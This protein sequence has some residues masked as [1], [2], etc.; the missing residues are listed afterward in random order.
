MKPFAAWLLGVVL[1]PFV[2]LAQ[3]PAGNLNTITGVQVKGGTVTITGTQKANFTTFTMTDPPRLV[4]DISEATFSGVPEEISVSS[5]TVTG[6]R[7]ASYGSESSSIARVLIGY[8]REVE[9]DI[10]S[11]GNNL[12]VRVAGGGEHAVAQAPTPEQAPAGSSAADAAAAARADRAAQEKA[13]ADAA[14]AARADREAQERA[15]AD[16]AAAAKR[17]QEAEAKRQAEARAAAQRQ[18]EEQARATA[19]AEAERKRQQEAE[20]RATAQAVEDKRR[21]EEAARASKQSAEDERR[22]QAQAAAEESQRKKELARTEA[23][24]KRAAQQAAEEER[25]ASAQA[26]AEERRVAEEERRSKARAAAKQLVEERRAQAQAEEEERRQ[27]Q[28]D[29]RAARESR[30]KS[31]AEPSRSGGGEVSSRRKTLTLVGFQQQADTSRVF[32]RTNEPV[33]YSVGEKGRT[34]VLELENTRVDSSNNTLPLDTSFFA[35]PVL[36]VDPSAS[37]RDV[38]ITIQLRQ[39]TPFQTRQDG[40]VISLDFQRT[41]R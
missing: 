28:A 32:I 13:A 41:G 9:T 17:D 30:Q 19:A 2:A 24:K 27:R 23:E 15:A 33:S 5:T 31:A 34:V 39:G 12:I 4:I 6:I 16:A 21:Q 3:A 18:Q 35:S 25:R 1:V 7:T 26:A 37:G 10:Q 38:R 8:D 29:A 14:A 22:A 11:Q 36:R 20:A 40:N